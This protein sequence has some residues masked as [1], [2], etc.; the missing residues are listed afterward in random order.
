MLTFWLH[1][2][3]FCATVYS[4]VHCDIKQFLWKS[5]FCH[6]GWIRCNHAWEQMQK[7]KKFWV[8]G[9]L[10]SEKAIQIKYLAVNKS[11]TLYLDNIG[12]LV[13]KSF[14]IIYLAYVLFTLTFSHLEDAL[15]LNYVKYKAGKRHKGKKRFLRCKRVHKKLQ[16]TCS[17]VFFTYWE[18][19]ELGNSSHHHGTTEP[20]SFAWYLFLCDVGTTRC[21]TA[22]CRL[23]LE[24]SG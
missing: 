16:K 14:L 17:T 10:P 22:D 13:T 4:C 11:H 15:I 2:L 6:L 5:S 9:A 19:A 21:Q 18:W 24:C 12:C 1:Y 7:D 23:G 8:S 20:K 3:C